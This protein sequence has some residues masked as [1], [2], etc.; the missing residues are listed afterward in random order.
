MEKQNGENVDFFSETNSV[1]WYSCLLVVCRN[2][3]C[4]FILFFFLVALWKRIKKNNLKNASNKIMKI[5]EL[6]DSEHGWATF[7]DLIW[8]DDKEQ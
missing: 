8:H 4:F 1:I 3:F 5:V 6:K 7:C 2:Q